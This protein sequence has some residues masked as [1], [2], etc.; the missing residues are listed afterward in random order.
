MS[1]LETEYVEVL[2]E[3][4]T[5]EKALEEVLKDQAENDGE[6]S[7]LKRVVKGKVWTIPW[8]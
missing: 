2:E 4:N 6:K 5:L 8:P 3:V 7:W 1:T